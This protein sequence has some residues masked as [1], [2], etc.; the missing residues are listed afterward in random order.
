MASS[1]NPCWLDIHWFL[2]NVLKSVV[3]RGVNGR[4]LDYQ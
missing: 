3:F 4:K 1:Q 2:G